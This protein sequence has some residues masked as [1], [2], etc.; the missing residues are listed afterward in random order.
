M[1]LFPNPASE[2][3]SVRVEDEIQ[4]I[5]VFN[6]QG[7]EMFRRDYEGI[8]QTNLDVSA[9]AAG[10]YMISVQTTEEIITERLVF[11]R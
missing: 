9:L 7:Q 3:V 2:M 4:Q 8:E 1:E 6:V 11:H 10:V 5:V